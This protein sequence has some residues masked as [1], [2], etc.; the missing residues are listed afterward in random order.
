[1]RI[2]PFVLIAAAAI[3]ALPFGWGLGVAIAYLIAGP[4]FGQLPAG[5]VPLSIVASIA[6]ALWPSLSPTIR[7]VAMAAG[8]VA[9]ILLGY[10]MS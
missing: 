4:N 5:T 7:F 2:P 9:F 1:M 10:L 3:F 8:T 6:F